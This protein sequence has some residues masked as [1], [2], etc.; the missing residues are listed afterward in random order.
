M[1][2]N[3]L[4]PHGWQATGQFINEE[5]V[6]LDGRCIKRIRKEKMGQKTDT[7]GGRILVVHSFFTRSKGYYSFKISSPT[8]NQ[9][10]AVGFATNDRGVMYEGATGVIFRWEDFW[11][12]C[13]DKREVALVEKCSENDVIECSLIHT[14]VGDRK[15]AIVLI[16]KNGNLITRHA[17]ETSGVVWPVISLNSPDSVINIDPKPI[18]D[19]VLVE[20][21]IIFITF[22]SNHV[23][24][25]S[26]MMSRHKVNFGTYYHYYSVGY[27]VFS[28]VHNVT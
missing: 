21:G 7:Q 14:R 27:N 15:Y 19:K 26:I 12:K 5:H 13:Y 6:K 2:T 20:T 17:L 9:D 8:P 18:L 1:E 28:Y 11:K 10:F 24:N 16:A 23:I 4:D 22:D 3:T 25:Q